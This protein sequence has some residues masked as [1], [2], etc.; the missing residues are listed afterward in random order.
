[1]Q[2]HTYTQTTNQN[3]YISNERGKEKMWE[4]G[5]MFGFRIGQKRGGVGLK[6]ISD[7][8]RARKR[9]YW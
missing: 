2:T 9:P 4:G 1:M 6:D 8:K 7:R 5:G 3:L